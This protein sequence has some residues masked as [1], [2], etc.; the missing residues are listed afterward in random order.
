MILELCSNFTKIF[1]LNFQEIFEDKFTSNVSRQY[2]SYFISEMYGTQFWGGLTSAMILSAL[3]VVWCDVDI[4][5]DTIPILVLIIMYAHFVQ[6]L[7]SDFS[8]AVLVFLKGKKSIDKLK[9]KH[10]TCYHFKNR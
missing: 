7:I 5:T 1:V 8:E 4:K 3:Y 6:I 9:V 10:K 2:T